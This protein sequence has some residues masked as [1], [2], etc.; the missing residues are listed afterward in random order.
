MIRLFLVGLGGFLGANLRYWVGMWSLKHASGF[1]LGTFLVNIIGCFGLAFLATLIQT[2]VAVSDNLR[3][4]LATGFFGALTT[5]ST[6][7]LE[8]FTLF[9]DGQQT[10]AIL[11]LLG[12]IGLGLAG[13]MLGI[14]L[15]SSL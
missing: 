15:G 7:S 8:A 9:A 12:S 6:F 11:Y 4:M 2:R 5:F 1:P 10:T 14:M 3:L 13:I